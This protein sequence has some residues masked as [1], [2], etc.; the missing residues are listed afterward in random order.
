[1]TCHRCRKP[2]TQ[3]FRFQGREYGA[4]CIRL[5]VGRRKAR[6]VA[7]VRLEHE[8]LIGGLAWIAT[9]PWTIPEAN[10]LIAEL[11]GQGI[12]GVRVLS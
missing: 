1:M 12:T 7:L 9:A 10:G 5:V 11:A 2:I 6:G 4:W 3:V 8:A